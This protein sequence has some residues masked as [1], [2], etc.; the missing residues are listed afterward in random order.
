[1]GKGH[2]G[3][4]KAGGLIGT[5]PNPPS[6]KKGTNRGYQ[7]MYVGYDAVSKQDRFFGA[8]GGGY[9]VYDVT[10]PAEPKLI[11]SATG[12]AGLQNGHTF[13][14]TPDGRYAVLQ[15]EYRYAPLRIIDLKPAYDTTVN[16]HSPPTA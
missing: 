14:P 10:N 5:V 4:E 15:S 11:T 3:K 12:V 8:G 2:A 1:M 9:Y 6:Q 7:D 16:P 13:T